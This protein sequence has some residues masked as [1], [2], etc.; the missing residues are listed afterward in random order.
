MLSGYTDFH[1]ITDAINRGA[2]Y[3]FLIKPWDDQQLRDSIGEA[4]R[5]YEPA[6]QNGRPPRDL[7]TFDP[8]AQNLLSTP[9]APADDAARAD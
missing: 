4:F 1:S 5:R 8:E 7:R 9:S 6:A 3:K 2:V